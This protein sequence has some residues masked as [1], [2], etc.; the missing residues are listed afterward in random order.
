MAREDDIVIWKGKYL[1]VNRFVQSVGVSL[2]KISSAT[3]SNKQCISGKNYVGRPTNKR[4]TSVSVARSR[5]TFEK[6][7]SEFDFI[8]LTNQKQIS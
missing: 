3:S 1:L 5:N 2:L 7:V 6:F 4:H 8:A